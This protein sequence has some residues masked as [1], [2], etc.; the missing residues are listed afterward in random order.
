MTQRQR[1]R[2]QRDLL[3][4]TSL[5]IVA[6]IAPQGGAAAG[7]LHA[8]LMRPAGFQLDLS[9]RQSIFFTLN[10]MLRIASLAF[11]VL[12]AAVRTVLVFS[13]LI[14]QSFNVAEAA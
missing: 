3:P 6:P 2:P 7:K 13:F 4:G 5:R 11:G 10:L 14:S 9:Q 8:D 12:G 1:Y